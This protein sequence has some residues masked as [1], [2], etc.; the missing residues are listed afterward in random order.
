MQFNLSEEE[1]AFQAEVRAFIEE[2]YVAT[3]GNGYEKYMR[4][5]EALIERGW[6]TH[7]WPKE[8]G[9]TGWNIV[10]H[11]IWDNELTRYNV[12]PTITFGALMIGPIIYTY[13]N[14]E[15]KE[16]FLPDIQTNRV[17]WCQGYSEP[18]AGSDLANL[19]TKATLTEDGS[20]YIVNGQKIWTS[21]AHVAQW[22][23]CLTRTSQEEKK[24]EGITFL[25]IDM[26]DP[27]V[28]VKPIITL[29]GKHSVNSVHLTDV[30]VPVENRIGEEGKGWT[31]AK[32]LLQHERTG[33]AGL[34]RS[35]V[36][37]ET[38]KESTKDVPDGYGTLGNNSGFQK[39]IAQLE[40][41]LMAAEYL[42]LKTLSTVAEGGAP[43][44]GSS[45]LKLKG[46]EF[47]QRLQALNVEAAGY[48]AAPWGKRTGLKFGKSAMDKYL[49][50]RAA[51]IYGGASEVQ[52][53]VIAKTVL[54]LS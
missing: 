9:G 34:T 16:R 5:L 20:H 22:M 11:W 45:T 50:G 12:P 29:G 33:L 40:I 2:H 28:E 19:K 14:E 48:Y 32:G 1:L 53:D 30:K 49:S 31:Y 52:K 6:F 25:L 21:Y 44:L 18:G 26:N 51:T 42:E 17:N 43:S 24:Q 4:W 38:L 3:Q 23:F 54:G 46:T 39:K 37:L 15:Q 41:E 35:A 7:K 47:Q 8:H 10:Q 36:A 13:G 27:G